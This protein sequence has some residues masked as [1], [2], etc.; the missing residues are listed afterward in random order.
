MPVPR[1]PMMPALPL[2][3]IMHCQDV[4]MVFLVAWG[5]NSVDAIV[6]LHLCVFTT[7]SGAPT[8]KDK[9]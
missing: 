4:F 7:L 3:E 6:V 1:V 9:I 8:T 2:M 5:A